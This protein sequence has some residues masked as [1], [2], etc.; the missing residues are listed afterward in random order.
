MRTCVLLTLM[1]AAAT[2]A[3]A[4][5]TAIRLGRLWDGDR[6]IDRAVV[7][8]E[9]DR[10]VRVASGVEIPSGA[11]VIDLSRYT[12][13]PGL[14]DAHTHIT[15]YW[16]RAPG[17]RPRGQRRLPAVTVFSGPGQRAADARGRR[18]D[19]ARLECVQRDRLRDA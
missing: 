9:R 1:L 2:D 11:T 18:H 14:I 13:L 10:I 4:Q 3:A 19:R 7:F 17:T 8:V 16:D 5:V 12:G 15:Y 6:V